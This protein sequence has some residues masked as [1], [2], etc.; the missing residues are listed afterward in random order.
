MG[1]EANES[2]A[3]AQPQSKRFS[4]EIQMKNL[5]LKEGPEPQAI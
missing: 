2:D 1:N 4:K 5:A 3:E